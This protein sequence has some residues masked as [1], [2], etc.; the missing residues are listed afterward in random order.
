M[1][2][3]D[4]RLLSTLRVVASSGK[5]SAAARSLHVSQPAVTAQVRKLEAQC[6]RPLLTRSVRGIALTEA[7][8][9]LV[10]YAAKVDDLLASAF[11]EVSAA[12][13]RGGLL[14]LGASTTSAMHLLPKLIA[15]FIRTVGPI[16][17]RIEEGNSEDVLKKLEAGEIPLGIVEGPARV[18]RVRLRHFVDDELVAVIATSAPRKLRGVRRVSDLMSVPIIWREVG[19]GTRTVVERALAKAL[20]KKRRGRDDLHPGGTAAIRAMAL[21]G[22]GVAFLSRL[23]IEEDLARGALRVLS[24][25]ELRIPRQFSWAMAAGEVPG[26]A[27]R[28][29]R[30]ASTSP[31]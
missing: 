9:R 29:L 13:S 25:G 12:P 22:L 4:P 28:F 30:F 27:G 6:G 11:E 23:S 19:S 14:H 7:G 2:E 20:G 8:E 3:L 15:S 17:V 24:L 10:R 5:I 26:L 21:E 16:A 18:P 1:S 31:T